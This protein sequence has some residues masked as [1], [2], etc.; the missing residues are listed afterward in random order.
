MHSDYPPPNTHPSCERVLVLEKENTGIDTDVEVVILEARSEG[1]TSVD[2]DGGE[3]F[4]IVFPDEPNR[5][6][7]FTERALRAHKRFKQTVAA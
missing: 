3:I 6:W 4:W 7:D 1:A 2:G 5:A